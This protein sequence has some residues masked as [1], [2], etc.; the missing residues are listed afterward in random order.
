M[1]REERRQFNWE[2]KH[3]II[4]GKIYRQCTQCNEWKV[5]SEEFY[6]RNKSMPEK[7]YSPECKKCSSKRSREIT[8]KNYD[9]VP[10]YFQKFNSK[11]E[12]KQYLLELTRERRKNGKYYDWLNSRPDKKKKYLEN[13]R[14]HDITTKEWISNKNFF[15][16]KN[17]ELVC[18]Y[19]GMTETEHKKK[20]KEQL[21]KEHVDHEGYNDVR[22][23]VPSCKIC[24][25][26]K[27]AFI[28][29]E[30]FREQE[31]FTEEKLA[32]IRLWCNEE[33]KKYIEDKPPY[34]IKHS[35]VYREDGT[36][37]LQAELWTVDEKR[38][39]IECIFTAKTKKEIINYANKYDWNN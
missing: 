9:R 39:T 1:T 16:D 32:K 27:K 11:P 29:E 3:K 6:L 24:N 10:G 21:H 14:D 34:R 38:N 30:W 35:R 26:S 18:A 19:C 5:E 15:K 33:Y 2:Q 36:Y 28:M 7:G 37:Y 23:C 31:F 17:G 20:Y 4:D 12:R 25:S 22:N 8:L 13:H